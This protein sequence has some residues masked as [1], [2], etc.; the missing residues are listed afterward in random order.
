MPGSPT[1]V[2]NASLPTVA[3]LYTVSAKQ[4]NEDA[5]NGPLGAVMSGEFSVSLGFNEDA[6]EGPLGTVMSAGFGVWGLEFS[7]D[8]DKGPLGAVMT[9]EFGV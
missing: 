5:D 1:F 3:G 9:G 2:L 6:D 8:A 4:L 7:E